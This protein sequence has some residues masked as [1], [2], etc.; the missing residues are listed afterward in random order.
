[1]KKESLLIV[2][3]LLQGAVVA[4]AQYVFSSLDSVWRFA[5]KQNADYNVR[6]LQVEQAR[7]DRNAAR[8]FLF[9]TV[10]A[11]ASGQDNIDLSVTPVPGEL[12]GQPGETINMKFGKKYNYAAGVTVNYNVLN[13][14]K[15]YQS[16]MATTNLE[17]QEANRDYFEQDLKQQ[18]GQLYYAALTAIK[19]TEIGEHDLAVADTLL[20]LS[21]D[22]FAQGTID[23]LELNQAKISRN[24]I[25]Q[26]L[27]ATMQYQDECLS[28]LKILLGLQSS[29]ELHLDET[30]SVQMASDG[31]PDLIANSTYTNVFKLQ[32]DYAFAEKKKAGAAFLPDLKLNG[33]WGANQFQDE[34]AFSFKSGDWNANS[35]IGLSVS[36]PIFNGMANRSNYR[37]AK[38]KQEI[39]G[40]NYANES[41]KSAIND[42]LT[43]RQMQ[44]NRQIAQSGESTFSLT[45]DNLKLA[46]LKYDEGLISMDAY[47]KVFDDYLAAESNYLNALSEFLSYK[48]IF[49][50]RKQ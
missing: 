39:A 25:A 45:A 13:W 21:E 24:T 33:F 41:R 4:N 46:A 43:Y 49:E 48:V 30:V 7:Q 37:S 10:S 26:Q 28:N 50:S 32:T 22:R 14:Q 27:E 34:L 35:Y 38:L 15:I 8:S 9:P 18:L 2:L 1:M 36:I 16:K 47:L 5:L 3:F 40:Q 6:L 17:L 31:L 20:S 12:L 19:A 23:A 29:D 11:A 44:R 42:Q